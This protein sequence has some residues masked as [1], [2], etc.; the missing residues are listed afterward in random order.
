MSGS[1]STDDIDTKSTNF[2]NF[3]ELN[4]PKIHLK[5]HPRPDY[6]LHL[7]RRREEAMQKVSLVVRS[8]ADAVVL[9]HDVEWSVYVIQEKQALRLD[10]R[11]EFLVGLLKVQL[12][13]V[14]SESGD[15][16]DM[17]VQITPKKS[18]LVAIEQYFNGK[19]NVQLLMSTLGKCSEIIKE[20]SEFFSELELYSAW[21]VEFPGGKM[22]GNQ[23]N[24]RND[25]RGYDFIFFWT[26]NMNAGT[27]ENHSIFT[28]VFNS[29]RRILDKP[30]SDF[31]FHDL[32]SITQTY[33]SLNS[34][35]GPKLALTTLI[36][37]IF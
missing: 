9:R 13:L 6:L 34:I 12:K 26:F 3:I 23:V 32:D 25:L 19:A 24:L 37:D 16:D 35:L 1:R 36:Q 22:Y 20:R 7:A 5:A 29:W 11:I 30:A 21:E 18:E 4:Y 31:R 15:V 27:L 10:H 28:P 14:C 33:L 17:T 8:V 2:T